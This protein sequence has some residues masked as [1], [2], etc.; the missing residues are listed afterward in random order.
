MKETL[1]KFTLKEI[2]KYIDNRI[3]KLKNGMILYNKE[4]YQYMVYKNIIM[5]LQVVKTHLK[6]K[7]GKE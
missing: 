6:T 2:D 3:N 4:E 5:E 1:D 7:M